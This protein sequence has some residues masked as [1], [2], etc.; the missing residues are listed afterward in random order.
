MRM[1]ATGPERDSRKPGGISFL[2][3][4]KPAAPKFVLL[5]TGGSLWAMAGV[6]LLFR[7]VRLIEGAPG[8]ASLAI[9]AAFFGSILFYKLVFEKVSFKY[10]GRILA[11]PFDK[12]CVFSFLSMRGY[13]TM[14]FMIMLGVVLRT[15]GVLPGDE[16][17][18]LY[19]AIGVSL[20]VSSFHFF[21]QG[22]LLR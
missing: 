12:P 4:C 13:V 5:L 8:H 16:V 2:H 21:R 22:L 18:A 11:L 7:G 6:L 9:A 14:A 3:S 17:G 10:I 20:G 1:P 19:L 15:S